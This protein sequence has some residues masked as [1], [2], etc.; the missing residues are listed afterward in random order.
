M[1]MCSSTA[2]HPCLSRLPL[3]VFLNKSPKWLA[4]NQ[5]QILSLVKALSPP[6]TTQHFSQC[7]LGMIGLLHSGTLRSLG[8]RE[9]RHGSGQGSR[10]TETVSV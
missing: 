1:Q 5:G 10:A 8:P 2:D 7:A 4:S 6:P 9:R 3:P